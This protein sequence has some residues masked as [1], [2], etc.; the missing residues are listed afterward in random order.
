MS[1]IAR[2][3]SDSS[4]DVAKMRELIELQK[5]IMQIE[6]EA[7]F[8]EAFAR[9]QDNMPTITKNG[10]IEIRDKATNE[11]KQSTPYGKYEDLDRVLKPLLKQER[12]VLSY[13]CKTT[14]DARIIVTCTLR[15]VKG[16]AISSDSAPLS[17]DTSGSKNNV[18]AAGSTTSY[19][20]RY[21]CCDLLNIVFEDEDTD[22]NSPLVDD[23][24]AKNLVSLMD[25]GELTAE[26]RKKFL[27]WLRADKAES[28]R[29]ND[30]DR[31]VAW[32]KKRAGISE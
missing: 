19:G 6:R 26:Q 9:L 3:A 4:I 28:V 2:A 17:L 14:A 20:K 12:M 32:L 29:V 8:N 10:R 25:A 15:H 1:V 31:G 13:T 5:D 21:S 27:K 30:Y 23:Q 7:A 11:I 16:H 24:Q 18:Q 22:G